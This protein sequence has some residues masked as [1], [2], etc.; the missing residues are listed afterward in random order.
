MAPEMSGERN[1]TLVCRHQYRSFYWVNVNRYEVSNYNTMYLEMSMQYKKVNMYGT[2]DR[3][4]T[5]NTSVIVSASKLLFQNIFQ[6]FQE[7]E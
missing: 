5:K 4:H 3:V 2:I 6:M 7:K 1:A